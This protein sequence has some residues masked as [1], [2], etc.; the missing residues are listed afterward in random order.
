MLEVKQSLVKFVAHFINS[1]SKEIG[2]IQTWE[3]A[4]ITGFT[5]FVHMVEPSDTTGLLFNHIDQC[6][7][8]LL[9][10]VN[11]FLIILY[12]WDKHRKNKK[13]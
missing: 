5:A 11:F 4:V 3:I 6:L 12:A 2:E 10:A 13:Q 7:S 9:K 1:A 8:I